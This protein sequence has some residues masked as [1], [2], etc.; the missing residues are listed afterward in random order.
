VGQSHVD[1]ALERVELGAASGGGSWSEHARQVAAYH[2]A[3]HALVAVLQADMSDTVACVSLVRR[4]G[5]GGGRTRLLPDEAQLDAGLHSRRY[6]L[7]RMR[8]TEPHSRFCL[9]CPFSR[10]P[11]VVRR[12]LALDRVLR[13]GG[14]GAAVALGGRVAEEVVYGTERVTVCAA[15]DLQHVASVAQRMVTQWGLTE[16]LGQLALTTSTT[17]HAT[18]ATYHPMAMSALSRGAEE[19]GVSRATRNRINADVCALVDDA[20]ADTR[21]LLQQHQVRAVCP[22]PITQ[23]CDK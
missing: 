11:Y 1:A 20:H 14:G 19:S 2:E 15:D 16:A 4:G 3:G 18:P 9:R 17:M 12:G 22:T 10:R 7:A 8:G 13:G 23:P 6:L 21:A 5:G